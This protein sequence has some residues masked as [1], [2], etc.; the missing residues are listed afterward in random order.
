[1]V[2]AHRQ[3]ERDNW[4]YRGMD[5]CRETNGQTETA[6]TM[7]PS[8]VHTHQYSLPLS[9][10]W[11]GL[12]P[13]SNLSQPWPQQSTHS[14]RHPFKT[15]NFQRFLGFWKTGC[16]LSNGLPGSGTSPSPPCVGQAPP[17][18]MG[19]YLMDEDG[20]LPLCGGGGGGGGTLRTRMVPSLP[21]V[22]VWGGGGGGGYLMD[23]DGALP[24][25][26]GVPYGRGQCHTSPFFL[27]PS[28]LMAEHSPPPPPPY[29]PS[30]PH[31]WL[32]PMQCQSSDGLQCSSL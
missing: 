18:S 31:S 20:A 27:Q 24:L 26:W 29:T 13:V 10:L 14:N 7:C 23:E 15:S 9:L 16:T 5:A 8:C 3:R 30:D 12:H 21:L 32:A 17:L 2:P 28:L 22:C 19:A 1:M 6:V 25:V 11:L 4:M